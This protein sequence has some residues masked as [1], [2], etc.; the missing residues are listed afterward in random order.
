MPQVELWEIGR[1][2][3]RHIGDRGA[4]IECEAENIRIGTVL[5]L[6][7]IAG[8]RRDGGDA[9]GAKVGGNHARADH[10]EMRCHDQAL[11]LVIR[12]IGEC[13]DNPGRGSAGFASAH[14]DA[15]HDAVGPRR[16]RHLQAVALGIVALNRIGEVDRLGIGRDADGFHG[17]RRQKTARQGE[18][19]QEK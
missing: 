14:L 4:G 12:I 15:A 18:D 1:A 2:Q 10:A 17:R 11:D 6:G 8:T 19:H 3:L 13:E 9:G 7:R 16:G 5:A